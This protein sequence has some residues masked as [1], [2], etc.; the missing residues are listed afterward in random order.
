MLI[1]HISLGKLKNLKIKHL[2]CLQTKQPKKNHF[3]PLVRNIKLLE[4]IHN[5]VCNS[6]YPLPRVGNKYFTTF[7]SDYSKYCHLYQIKSKDKEF[8]MCKIY[9]NEVGK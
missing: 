1:C 3:K 4:Q 2:I 9:K 5:V 6:N 8:E 7:M